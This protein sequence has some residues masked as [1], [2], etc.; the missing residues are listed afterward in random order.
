MYFY[1]LGPSAN[2]DS[3]GGGGVGGT[4]TMYH[5]AVLPS[6]PQ[7]DTLSPW[8]VTTGDTGVA[9]SARIVDENG[10]AVALTGEETAT[11]NMRQD[12]ESTSV[13]DDAAAV[14]V[15]SNDGGPW[16]ARFTFGG[17]D[18]IPAAGDYKVTFRVNGLTYPL[19][20]QQPVRVQGA[21]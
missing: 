5:V 21:I 2:S 4:L 9:V 1:G 11:F 14:L 7:T 3:E 10:A 19:G 16:V 15:A 6:H 8:R 12:G 20:R 18:P 13:I 17:D